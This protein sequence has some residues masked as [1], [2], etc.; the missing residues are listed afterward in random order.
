MPTQE[1][2]QIGFL[3][4]DLS[5]SQLSFF[6]IKNLNDY[7]QKEDLEA[8]LFF[9]NS[10]S[11]A[12]KPNVPLMAINEIWNFDGVLI[13]TD[14]NTTLSL[15]KCFAPAK[16]IFYVWDL[17]WMRNIAGRTKEFESVVQA[18]NDESIQ[19][20]ARSEDHAKAIENI[21]NRKIKH[22]VEN[23]NIEKLVRIA[24]E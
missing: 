17:E 6:L 9:E 11:L 22:I 14:V 18:F 8:V 4:N 24:N 19:L 21:S 2:K 10:S 12:I 23:F 1:N 13:S 16:K 15:K 20:I 5:A 3:V 7:K